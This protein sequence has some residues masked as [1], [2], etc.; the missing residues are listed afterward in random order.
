MYF[1]LAWICFP[2]N[3]LQPAAFYPAAKC[4][5]LEGDVLWMWSWWKADVLSFL[6]SLSIH[7]HMPETQQEKMDCEITASHPPSA[8][9]FP[10][11][12]H[13]G[14]SG[15]VPCAQLTMLISFRRKT[16]LLSS[17]SN[18]YIS[19][20][21]IFCTLSLTLH[22]GRYTQ[23]KHYILILKFLIRTSDL[24]GS[25]FWAHRCLVM[26]KSH[27]FLGGMQL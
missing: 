14:R 10:S 11:H 16:H 21:S 8:S 27:S 20:Q 3:K 15:A 25:H 17:G 19:V 23:Y 26:T 1:L 4:W 5:S 2:Q 6:L 22:V 7:T 13:L 9:H 24:G 18:F 12:P